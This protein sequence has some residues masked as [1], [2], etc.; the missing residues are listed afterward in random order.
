L[1][2]PVRFRA[3]HW[4]GAA[5]SRAT[6]TDWVKDERISGLQVTFE[7]GWRQAPFAAYF[8]RHI[9]NELFD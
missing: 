7:Q 9:N 2:V 1:S 4:G 5:V 6:I 8:W 3:A